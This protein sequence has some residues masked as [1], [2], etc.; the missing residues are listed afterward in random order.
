MFSLTADTLVH[1]NSASR[2][3]WLRVGAGLSVALWCVLG[4]LSPG[5]VLEPCLKIIEDCTR[6]LHR[7]VREDRGPAL[8][9]TA[10]CRLTRKQKARTLLSQI[11]IYIW[12][13]QSA[14]AR[15]PRLVCGC[16]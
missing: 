2:S 8:R 11:D 14:L 1:S 16:R 6:A 9:V 4:V 15:H 7:A 3:T 12:A 10:L 13:C 5:Q